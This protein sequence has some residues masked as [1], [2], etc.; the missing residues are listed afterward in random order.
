MHYFHELNTNIGKINSD[1][2]TRINPPDCTNITVKK[3]LTSGEQFQYTVPE[4]GYYRT[5]IYVGA[6]A[7]TC[8]TYIIINDIIVAYDGRLT[9]SQWQY[10]C[11]DFIYLKKGWNVSIQGAWSNGSGQ[12]QFCKP[13]E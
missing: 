6:T 11:T 13:I 4:D 5:F 2:K 9:S 10:A 1:L 3:E 7:G 8:S 12:L